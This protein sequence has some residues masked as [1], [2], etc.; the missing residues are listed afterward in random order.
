MIKMKENE[1]MADEAKAMQN[2]EYK[3]ACNAALAGGLPK[4]KRPQV[5]SK[6]K[7]VEEERWLV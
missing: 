5:P 6:P 1:K 2:A 7:V 4:P 3:V